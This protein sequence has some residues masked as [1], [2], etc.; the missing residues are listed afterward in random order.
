MINVYWRGELLTTT[1]ST[2]R[3]TSSWIEA[4]FLPEGFPLSCSQDY[5]TYQKWDTLQALCSTLVGHLATAGLLKA[6]GVGDADA[7]A[8]SAALLW[9]LGDGV[10]HVSRV[11][12]AW[13]KAASLDSFS[14]QYRLV[15][16][17]ANDACLLLN[18]LAASWFLK[19]R[20]ALVLCVGAILRAIVS[21]AGSATRAAVVVHQARNGNVSDVAA[22]DGSQ[23]TAV[24]LLGL[25]VGF[26]L[27]PA[28]GSSVFLTYLAYALLTCT[29][30]YANWRAV[31]SLQFDR[32]NPYRL[33]LLIQ[34]FLQQN[35]KVLSVSQCNAKEPILPWEIR[36]HLIKF[37]SVH[38]GIRWQPQ[39]KLV[40]QRPRFLLMTNGRDVVLHR[41]SSIEDMVE[42]YFCAR[43]GGHHERF[44]QFLDLCK[45]QGWRFDRCSLNSDE[46]RADWVLSSPSSL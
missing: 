18:L 32:V 21:V 8:M 24:N 10:G 42:A 46:W 3:S 4:A 1:T 17:V 43:G 41:D 14:K 44:L 35:K 38:M 16:D 13:H 33:D 23:E 9:M 20:F 34:S 28:V 45:E 7:S 36:S 22:K 26:A 27:I 2:T 29:H 5:L 40:L 39:G 30:L 12:F 15:A 11:F 6:S 19:G 25:L 31:S 37:P